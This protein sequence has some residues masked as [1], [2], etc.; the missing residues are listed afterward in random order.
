MISATAGVKYN[1]EYSEALT[2]EL[3]LRL[4]R[5]ER[6]TDDDFKLMEKEIAQRIP[7]KEAPS[8]QEFESDAYMQALPFILV[9]FLIIGYLAKASYLDASAF[10]LAAVLAEIQTVP[11][12][13]RA[14][15]VTA[16]VLLYVVFRRTTQRS[17]SKVV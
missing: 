17:K 13:T 5:G 3:Q 8:R 1:T 15:F 10:L 14:A 11:N 16:T 9:A 2:A 6:V 4:S 7:V 12:L